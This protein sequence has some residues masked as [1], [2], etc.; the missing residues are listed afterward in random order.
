MKISYTFK[1]AESNSQLIE[2]L[3][4]KLTKVTRLEMKPVESAE[5][6]FRVNGKAMYELEIKLHGGNGPLVAHGDG[7]NF[8]TAIERAVEHLEK[9]MK[10]RKERIQGHKPH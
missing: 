5:A 10:R 9:Q 2:S 1:G 7:D 4:E 3:E 8:L 6:I